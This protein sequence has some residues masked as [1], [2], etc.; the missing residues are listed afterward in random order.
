MRP[1]TIDADDIQVAE[2]FDASLLHRTNWIDEFLAHGRDEKFIVTGTKGF[3][4]TLLLKAKR[5]AFQQ[6]KS[7]VC[8]P[9]NSLLDKPIG[10][11]IFSA[12]MIELYG[13]TS[14]NWRK[15]WLISIAATVL[16]HLGLADGLWVNP[17][18]AALLNDAN[19]RGVIDHFVNLLDFPRGDLFKSA[20]E[21]D[22][23]LVP[24]LRGINSPVAIFIDSVDEYFNK[25]IVTASMRAS[26]AGELAANVWHLSQMALVETAYQLRRV[27]HHIKVFAAIRKEAFCKL[28]D[29]TPMVQQY[30]GSTIDISYSPES[31]R[32]ILLNNIRKE[33]DRNLV[34]AAALR[35][36]P[37]AAFLG[38]THVTHSATGQREDVFEYIYRHT[39]QRPRDLMT[40]G[41]KLSDIAPAERNEHAVKTAVNQ[42]ATEIAREYLNEISPYLGVELE[43]VFALLRSNVL[44]RAELERIFQEHNQALRARGALAGDREMH[45]FCMLYKAGLLGHVATDHVS[46]QRVQRFLRPGER[47]F[48]PDGILPRS[49]H[50][51]VHPVL[52]ELIL[53]TNSDYANHV[54][55]LNVVG[56]G[57]AWHE[58]GGVETLCVLRAD[59]RE[60]S[61][62]ME[63]GDIDREVRQCLRDAV[64]THATTCRHHEVSGGDSLILVHHDPSAVIKVVRRIMEDLFEVQGNPV[65]RVAIDYGPVTLSPS[66]THG[67]VL[68]GPPFRVAARL[69]PHVTPNEIWVTES[70]KATLER[71]PTLYE[72]VD[73]PVGEQSGGAWVNGRLNIKKPGSREPD[74]LLRVFRI[75][76]RSVRS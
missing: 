54:D 73:I 63:R 41:Q 49:T 65:L 33:K 64:H 13:H 75:E 22:S 37:I 66:P 12:E 57:R 23:H 19:L 76:D 62:I 55:R 45:V 59:I 56:D 20:T 27:N 46:A 53:R 48:D 38:L 72:A 40:I 21:T 69:E 1:W 2:D 4:K 3:G 67:D 29:T 25:H 36:D 18:L 5:V 71:G 32:E 31:L 58:P 60:F 7:T 34:R 43:P 61:G 11:K 50:Y 74:Q 28:E 70:F 8:L 26:D 17:R 9:E 42:G 10:D 35:S 24:R 68:S 14:D 51:L 52:A 16:K 6:S 30:R 39:L 44:P 47:T 15:V